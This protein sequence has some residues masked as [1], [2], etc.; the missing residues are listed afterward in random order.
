MIWKET[1]LAQNRCY[2]GSV[3]EIHETR[4]GVQTVSRPR[5]ELNGFHH[6]FRFYKAVHSRSY[7]AEGSSE[8]LHAVITHDV[9]T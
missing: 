3:K 2:P 1:V 7:G 4:Q 6:K 9:I 8:I 5:F